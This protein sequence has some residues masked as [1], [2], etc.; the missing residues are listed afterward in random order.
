MLDTASRELRIGVPTESLPPRLTE[1]S[2]RMK[3]VHFGAVVGKSPS[4]WHAL[5]GMFCAGQRVSIEDLLDEKG[6]DEASD[7]SRL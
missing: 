5:A 1:L 7:H 4:A 2:R 6:F 3:T